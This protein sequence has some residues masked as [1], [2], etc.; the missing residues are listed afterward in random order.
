[1]T[2]ALIYPPSC[3]PTAPYI[4]VPMLTGYLRRHN[5]PV[6][7]IDAN[8]EAYHCL[9]NRASLSSMV[10]KIASHWRQLENKGCLTHSDQIRFAQIWDTAKDISW[11]PD[12]IDESVALFRD[13][14][15]K[16]FFDP[17]RYEQAVQTI[18][19]CLRIIS[20]AY[21]PLEMDF[22]RY[23]TPFSLLSIEQI[24]A[25]AVP[26][27]N[28]F[29][30]YFLDLCGRLSAQ[31]VKI[32]GI[33]VA[34]PGQIQPAYSLA[35]LM[36][37]QLPR[38]H[39][40]V[41]GPAM[42]QLLVRQHEDKIHKALGP[43]HSAVLYEGEEALLSLVN[44][45]NRDET[46]ERIL[47][48][49]FNFGRLSSNSFERRMDSGS[50]QA[51]SGMTVSGGRRYNQNRILQ[52]GQRA[53]LETL[54]APDFDGLPLELYFSP[55]LVLP[56]DPSRGCYW[57]KCAFCHYGLTSK[58]TTR[59]RE[60]P[61]NQVVDHLKQLSERWKCRYF[62]FSQDTYAPKTARKLSLALR[63]ANMDIQWATDI[64]P[65][66]DLTP[67]CCRDYKAGGALS[68]ALGIESAS[69]RILKRINKG[70]T[71][72]QMRSAIKNLAQAGIAAEAM[73]FTGFPTESFSD[74]MA[75]LS[76]IEKL[77]DRIG[78]FICGRFGLCHGSLV[79]SNP[80]KYGIESIWRLKGDE[81]GT[82]LFYRE[83]AE[84]KT[85]AEDERIDMAVEQLS[86]G[87]WLHDYPWAGSLSTAHTIL[88]YGRHGIDAF[89][90]F[91]STPRGTIRPGKISIQ[92]RRYNAN[93]IIENVRENETE[94]W[95]TLI[96]DL[97]TVQPELYHKISR[98][99]PPVLPSRK[100]HPRIKR[101][102]RR[103]R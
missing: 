12:A 80:E 5:V 96:H 82:G 78:L 55:E 22:S 7:P 69:K 74:A 54:P 97:K 3:D 16:N 38:T 8:V 11:A 28:P 94:I 95:D 75:T 63:A 98:E 67:D 71:V 90:R 76:F 93:A 92:S 2:I 89:R 53:R 72:E 81:F 15:G 43:F 1:M 66:P 88:W 24:E 33:S 30:S 62:Y 19:A 49:G 27:R 44:M 42:T 50:P 101:K 86:T 61:I 58:G 47:G 9:L 102:R 68:M 17:I 70:V 100:F 36:R 21:A 45:L 4:S 40:T 56:Y 51:P 52:A 59:Y 99:F 34:F 20:A 35:F 25:D 37:K 32:A 41:G 48:L 91:A 6:I 85:D 60:R 64:R 29:H 87:W 26:E 23:R 65:E 83:V 31:D 84:P 10:Q 73:C 46:P 14:S 77:Q 18:Q 13:R 103:T 39:I 57:G 79:A